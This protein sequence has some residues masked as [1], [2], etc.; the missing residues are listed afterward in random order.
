MTHKMS[1]EQIAELK[2]AFNMFDLDGGGS[3]ST[4]ELGYVMRALGMNPTEIEVV[5]LINQVT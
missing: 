2:D 4:R 3:I 5:E 1:E